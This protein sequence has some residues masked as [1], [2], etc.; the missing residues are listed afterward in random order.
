M[1][2]L[3]QVKCGTSA[4]VFFSLPLTSPRFLQIMILNIRKALTEES[5]SVKAAREMWSFG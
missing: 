1:Q 2:N 4:R 5:T 3:G